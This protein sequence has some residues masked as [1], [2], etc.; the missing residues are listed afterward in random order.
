MAALGW[1]PRLFGMELSP[2]VQPLQIDIVLNY[3]VEVKKVKV[4]ERPFHVVIVD[5][6]VRLLK[7][8]KLDTVISMCKSFIR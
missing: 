7:S 3:P 8:S 4:N 5:T 1:N 6:F 2:P